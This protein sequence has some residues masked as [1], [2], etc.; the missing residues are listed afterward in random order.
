MSDSGDWAAFVKVLSESPRKMT[1]EDRE[2]C[3]QR[4]RDL[5][6][7][8]TL[9]EL[10]LARARLA[11]WITN[12]ASSAVR[13]SSDPEWARCW[14]YALLRGELIHAEMIAREAG[15]SKTSVANWI[16][17]HRGAPRNRFVASLSGLDEGFKG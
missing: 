16:L 1:L 7:D 9:D 8:A 17:R 2:R 4:M 13:K 5:M 14:Q 11:D 6:D 12:E 10:R 15:K 3:T